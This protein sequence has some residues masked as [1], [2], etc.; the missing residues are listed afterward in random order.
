[1]ILAPASTQSIYRIAAMGGSF[2]VVFFSALWFGSVA[3]TLID[4]GAVNQLTVVYGSLGMFLASL[5]CA[6]GCTALSAIA[7]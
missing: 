3:S 2:L 1:M 7:P 5:V 4:G 6:G